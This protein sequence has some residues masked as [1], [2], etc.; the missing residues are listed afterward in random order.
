M[1]KKSF[2]F[3]VKEGFTNIVIDIINE[4]LTEL[5]K[6]EPFTIYE[7]FKSSNEREFIHLISFQDHKAELDHM[8]SDYVKDFYSKLHPLCEISPELVNLYSL[9]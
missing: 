5:K 2:R 1:I 9:N 6:N 7:A 3:K 4:F 8:D